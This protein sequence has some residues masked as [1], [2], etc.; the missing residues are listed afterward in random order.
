MCIFIFLQQLQRLLDYTLQ[1]SRK[2]ESQTLG[3][4]GSMSGNI[5]ILLSGEL[6]TASMIQQDHFFIAKR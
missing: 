1:L 6:R 4:K 2:H 3:R 5:V